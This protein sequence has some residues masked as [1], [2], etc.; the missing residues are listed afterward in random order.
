[1]THSGSANELPSIS[2]VQRACEH[3]S[4]TVVRASI[5]PPVRR[6]RLST[7]SGPRVGGHAPV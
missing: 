4:V 1:M 6:A 3:R 7:R 2:T 5:A